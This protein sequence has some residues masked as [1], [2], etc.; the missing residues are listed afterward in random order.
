MVYADTLEGQMLALH[1]ALEVVVREIQKAALADIK[2]LLKC[3]S[4]T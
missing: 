4:R 3:L 2:R 1:D